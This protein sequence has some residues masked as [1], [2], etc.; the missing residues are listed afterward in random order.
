MIYLPI[1]ANINIDNIKTSS[2]AISGSIKK[3]II[4][5]DD[6]PYAEPPI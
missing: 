5:W 4:Y 6:I 1:F 3:G 2:G